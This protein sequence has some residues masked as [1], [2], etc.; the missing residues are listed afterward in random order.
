MSFINYIFIDMLM[1]WPLGTI[2]AILLIIVGL[3]LIGLAGYGIFRAIDSWGLP[4]KKG[5]GK[6][7]SKTYSPESSTMVPVTIGK[8]TTLQRHRIPESW[9]VTIA[10]NE[11]T[12]SCSVKESFFERASRGMQVLVEFVE[13]RFSK[14]IYIKEIY[15]V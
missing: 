3:F 1:D 14:D 10:V 8:V 2:V 7:I 13:G 6:I 9:S 5:N 4:K 15:E 12:S 11:K